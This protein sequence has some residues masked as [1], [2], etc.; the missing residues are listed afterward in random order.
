MGSSILKKLI[1]S[2]IWLAAFFIY[3]KSGQP[4][5]AGLVFDPVI[6]LFFSLVP[7]LWLFSVS[8]KTNT[9]LAVLFLTGTAFSSIFHND[10]LAEKFAILTYCFLVASV[11]QQI[12]L[13]FNPKA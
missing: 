6:N 3:Q 4:W 5:L 1:I 10:L 8:S 9:I 2:Y 12:K 13:L 11:L 7:I